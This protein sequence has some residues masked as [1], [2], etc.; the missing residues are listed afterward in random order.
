MKKILYMAATVL[1]CSS[2]FHVNSNFK[3]SF[4]GGK[5]AIK[6][7][8]QLIGKNFDFKDFDSITINGHADVT[9][10]QSSIYEVQVHT[11]ENIFEWLDYKVDGNT[12][13]IET[14]DHR[15]IRATKY[16]IDIQAP[17]LKKLVVNGAS[18][19]EIP[20]LRTENDLDIEINGAGDLS[21]DRVLCNSMTLKVNGAADADLT[22]ISVLKDLKIEVNGAGDVNVTG[23]A[24]NVSLSVNGAGDIDATGLKVTGEVSKHASGLAKI[25][26]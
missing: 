18:D 2:C 20:N 25:K 8:G 3:G 13:I 12:L 5:D 9:F 17:A 16:S 7:E 21:F 6:G 15:E 23:N 19:F 10:I 1:L 22:S 24:R 4:F 26:M 11:Q 14:K